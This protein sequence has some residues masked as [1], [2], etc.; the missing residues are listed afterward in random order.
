[1]P[2][3]S[4]TKLE[5]EILAHRL[6]IPE[7]IAEGLTDYDPADEDAPPYS[8]DEAHAVAERLC[9]EIEKHGRLTFNAQIDR[10]VIADAVDG[11][12]FPS[13]VNDAFDCDDLTKAQVAAYR[14]AYRSIEA[15]LAAE[16]IAAKFPKE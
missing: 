7:C 3:L 4:F 11:A 16:G 14:R 10:D 15:K 2:S 5:I 12:T 8:F 13:L 1:M 6:S 9:D